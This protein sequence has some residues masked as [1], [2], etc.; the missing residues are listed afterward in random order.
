[1][2][3]IERV[4]YLQG[5]LGAAADAIAAGVDL[6]GYFAWSLMDNFEWGEGYRSRFGLVHVDY[7]TQRR[8]PKASAHW[9]RDL[10]AAHRS[11]R[12]STGSPD[13]DAGKARPPG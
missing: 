3:D 10:I 9:Y 12:G 7:G 13:D 5:Y 8:T 1:M 4:A 2:R 6:R 11:S